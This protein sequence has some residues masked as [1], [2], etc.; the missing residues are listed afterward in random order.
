[1][2]FLLIYKDL[3]SQGMHFSASELV[4]RL[5][6]LA[7]RRKNSFKNCLNFNLKILLTFLKISDDLTDKIYLKSS[8]MFHVKNLVFYI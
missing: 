8:T 2:F 3:K 5:F 1:M 7:E 6:V 4:V